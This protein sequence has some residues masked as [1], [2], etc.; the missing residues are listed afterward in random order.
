MVHTINHYIE[1]VSRNKIKNFDINF[2]RCNEKLEY[3]YSIYGVTFHYYQ[4]THCLCIYSNVHKLLGTNKIKV[5]DYERYINKLN[6]VITKA[7]GITNY[8]LILS[9]LDMYIDLKCSNSEELHQV[10]GILNKSKTCYKYMKQRKVYRTSLKLGGHYSMCSLNFYDKYQQLKDVFGIEDNNYLNVCRFEIQINK[11]KLKKL[12]NE[13]GTPRHIG[14]YFKESMFEK[15]YFDFLQDF[16]NSG[17]Y[18]HLDKEIEIIKNSGYSQTIK[19]NLLKFIKVVNI[20]NLTYTSNY[21]CYN[22]IKKYIKLLN[23]INLNPICLSDSY[24]PTEMKNLLEQLRE[25]ANKNYFKKEL[26]GNKNV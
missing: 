24:K 21:F 14:Y 11:N 5:S 1:N 9:R 2:K 22:T 3:Y 4:C 20:T 10:L 18:I 13:N 15:L 7:T 16:F 26:G 25:I 17:N 6:A 12:L 23:Q 19:L 8:N